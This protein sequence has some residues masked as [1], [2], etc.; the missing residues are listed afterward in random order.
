[1]KF[2]THVSIAGGI[3]QAPS[4]AHGLGC[5]CFQL[6]TRSPRGGQPPKLTTDL[7]K[8]FKAECKKY[9]LSD[10]YIHAPYFINFGSSNKRI[11][12]GSIAVVRQE[13]ERGSQ[14]GA[15][16]IMTHL[17]S[18]KDMGL[19]KALTQTI[20]GLSKVL[21]DYKG[22]TKLLIENSA[23]SGKIMGDSFEDIAHILKNIPRGVGVC[24]DTTHA[25]VSGYD[26]RTVASVKK[27]LAEFDQAIGL[28]K[29]K[30]LH[31][32]DSEVPLNARVDRHENIG[33]GKIGREGFTTLVKNNKLR[34]V[35]MIVE[36]P[37]GE[38]K[39]DARVKDIKLLKK[40]RN[41][42]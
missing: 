12:H 6:F 21:A 39:I 15:K 26:L 19:K 18:A 31:G 30:L 16:C 32:N 2:G 25:F 1:M 9:K 3:D 42:E 20:T 11:Y 22:K 33:Q 40:L 24:L 37:S 29:L 7:V 4:R 17:G 8:N 36:T 10:Y 23:G 5:E 38:G 28:A 27:T 35:N 41:H 13:L 14:I 34:R